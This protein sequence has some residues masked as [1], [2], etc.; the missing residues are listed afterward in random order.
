M[1]DKNSLFFSFLIIFLVFLVELIGGIVSNSLALLSDAGH[2]LTD[3]L[4]LGLAL[5]A[6]ILSARPATQER[7]YGYYRLEI[8]SALFNGSLLILIALYIFY[9]AYQRFIHPAEIKSVLMLVVAVIGL[10]ANFV[11]AA[12]LFTRAEQNLNIRGALL[13]V[14]SDMFSSIGVV[15]G[16]LLIHFKGWYLVDPI[17]GILIGILILRG[18]ALLV[19][20]SINVL[21]ESV[22]KG[23]KL[24]EVVQTIRN[25]AGIKDLH[26]L[27]LWSITSGMNAISAHVVID[28]S[29][30]TRAAEILSKVKK[31][32]KEKYQI[33]HSTFQTECESCPEGLVCRI[34]PKE[35]RGH[36]HGR[37][38]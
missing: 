14:L 11:A 1:N 28:D 17:L 26:D 31:T 37:G 34:E 4:A 21:M 22:P 16:G 15:I 29:E 32:L 30:I 10:L 5:F 12:I 36:E 19:L 9:Q 7:T 3:T 35:E 18:A 38:H 33:I 27:H 24:E 20:E 8:L 2:M 6:A 13:H 25:V 23:I